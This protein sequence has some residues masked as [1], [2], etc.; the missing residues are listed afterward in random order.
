[1]TTLWAIAGLSLA[2]PEVLA[3]LQHAHEAAQSPAA[4]L[5][6]LN[7]ETAAGLEAIAAQIIP[8]DGELAL[9]LD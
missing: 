9:Y 3:A 2:D 4:K 7:A 5:T 6:Y 8:A 1:M